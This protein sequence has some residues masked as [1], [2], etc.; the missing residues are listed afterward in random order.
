MPRGRP[1]KRKFPIVENDTS[2]EEQQPGQ[3]NVTNDIEFN[4]NVQNRIEEIFVQQPGPS[5]AA[6]PIRTAKA[7]GMEKMSEVIMILKE[8]QSQ[9]HLDQMQRINAHRIANEND[10]ERNHSLEQERD[11]SSQRIANENDAQ[12]NQRLED[13]RQRVSQRIANESDA[14]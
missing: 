10:E 1:K 12:R 3:S 2:L 13:M 14:Q 9:E 6:R 8:S 4:L 7:K 11:R 5:N